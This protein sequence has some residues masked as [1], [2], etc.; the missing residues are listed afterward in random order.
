MGKNTGRQG[1]GDD[2]STFFCFISLPLLPPQG[3]GVLELCG[4]LLELRDLPRQFLVLGFQ[5]GDLVS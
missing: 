3:H 4:L 1:I 5:P 2:T